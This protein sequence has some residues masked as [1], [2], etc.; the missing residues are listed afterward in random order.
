MGSL[1]QDYSTQSDIPFLITFMMVDD[2]TLPLKEQSTPVPFKAGVTLSTS[3]IDIRGE[4]IF[5]RIETLF[6]L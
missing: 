3:R 2:T 1:L 5:L 4:L 6:G